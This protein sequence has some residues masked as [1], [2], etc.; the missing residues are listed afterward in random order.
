MALS[1]EGL[2][3]V[4][5]AAAVESVSTVTMEIACVCTHDGPRR[6]EAGRGPKAPPLD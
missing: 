6:R 2:S 4:E 1:A 5:A 3:A